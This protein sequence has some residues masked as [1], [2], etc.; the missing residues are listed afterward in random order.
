MPNWTLKPQ[1]IVDI[2]KKLENVQM[3][4]IDEVSMMTPVTL[5][6]VDFHLRQVCGSEYPFGGKDIILVGDMFQFPP[7]EQKFQ[8]KAALYQAVIRV[9][10]GQSTPNATYKEGAET[11]MKF[12]MLKL[13]GQERAEPLYAQWL[14][15]LRDTDYE[16]PI[17]DA[18]LEKLKVLSIKDV[19]RQRE[20]DWAF[21]PI[22]V[23]GHHERREIIKHKMLKFGKRYNE[24]IFT[25]NCVWRTKYIPGKGSIYEEPTAT[26]ATVYPELTQYFV[27]GAKCVLT[28][29]I[30]GFRKGTN[31]TYVGIVW[32][33]K[34]TKH[35]YNINTMQ[36]GK[37]HAVEQPKYI[38]VEI[39]T[40]PETNAKKLICIK[41]KHETF[42][43]KFGTR[44]ARKN[45][46]KAN[47]LYKHMKRHQTELT[48]AKT[49]HSVQGGTYDSI[50]LSINSC[51]TKA[52]K[53]KDLSL[54]S[55]LVGLTRVHDFNEHRIL[56]IS[57]KDLKKLKK[58]KHDPLL[59]IFFKSYDNNG[60]F[61]PN[62]AKKYE[63][64]RETKAKLQLGMFNFKDMIV[65]DFQSDIFKALDIHVDPP[66]KKN[67]QKCF[68]SV[69]SEGKKLL[70][71]LKKNDEIR[72]RLQNPYRRE[73]QQE[74]IT[75]LPVRKVKYYARR[76]GIKLKHNKV[77]QLRTQL[78]KIKKSNAKHNIKVNISD[79]DMLNF[80]ET[81][82]IYTENSQIKEDEDIEMQ[83]QEDEDI[84]TQND[85][86]EYEYYQ[87]DT[88]NIEMQIQE[89]ENDAKGLEIIDKGNPDTVIPYNPDIIIPYNNNIGK[90]FYQ[91][92]FYT[93][94]QLENIK[95]RNIHVKMLFGENDVDHHRNN[96]TN[97]KHWGGQA[98]TMGH[99]DRSY[100]FGIVTT[101]KTFIDL[102]TFKTLIDKQFLQL[103]NL[104]LKGYDI[105]IPTPPKQFINQ[106]PNK[107]Y[108]HGKQYVFH[109]IGTNIANLK[110]KYLVYIQQKIDQLNN[111]TIYNKITKI[112]CYGKYN[113]NNIHN[114]N[115]SN[116][117]PDEDIDLNYNKNDCQQDEDIDLINDHS[118]NQ[119]DE[120][121]E[122]ES[123]LNTTF[124]RGTDR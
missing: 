14:N 36:T 97:R 115:P 53:I 30:Y 104:L 29:S 10:R 103:K 5:A 69:H 106:C 94:P 42:D 46:K 74:C 45:N 56:P 102:K 3:I 28:E 21:T 33:D 59:K 15:R 48:I 83:T 32:D 110:F 66:L 109:N 47:K 92:E 116:N 34:K 90:I 117:E 84:E 60:N 71:K 108:N 107:F 120:S 65:K 63:L 55:L 123:S 9:A 78:R 16:C 31:G 93:I 52:Q 77:P 98:Q 35:K 19:I 37:I 85:Q 91:T 49:Y 67:Y 18:W 11:F 111:Y 17:D 118:S 79:Y 64:M 27:R 96:R 13:K 86:N 7:V 8:D 114:T 80:I 20:R 44:Q 40:D 1:Q 75:N 101:F 124:I 112:K 62:E 23:S 39:I 113:Q 73:L 57:D 61:L 25:W 122:S 41:P 43:D 6:R 87:T 82:E 51:N 89:D 99:Y 95:R 4:V 88:E 70:E 121:N 38:I 2:S 58:L 76:F 50:V 119:G 100:A 72:L 26:C 12:K 24:P 54:T 81:F 22:L 105:V 68:K